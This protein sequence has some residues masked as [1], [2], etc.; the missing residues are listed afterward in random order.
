[1][2]PPMMPRPM[3][4]PC[5]ALLACTLSVARAES[6]PSPETSA[7]L[8]PPDRVLELFTSHGCSSCPSADRLLG[9]LLERDATL[10]GLEYHVDYWN[11]LVHGNAGNFVDPFSDPAWTRRQHDY[12]EQ[13]LLGRRD[14][15]T[16]QA[17]VDGRHVAVGSDAV[18]IE[19]ALGAA[20]DADGGAPGLRVERSGNTVMI[21]VSGL[22]RGGRGRGP[23]S[24]PVPA[25]GEVALVH[26][27][28]ETRTPITGGENQGL[29]LV[30]HRVVTL[31]ESLGT[32]DETGALSV[33]AKAPA[34]PSEGCA[35]LV[36]Y[37]DEVTRLA[38]RLCPDPV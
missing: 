12:A 28:R 6:A 10:I 15:Y 35:V 11:S 30:N 31:V 27:L 7:P 16:P 5:V 32:V 37:G 8:A 29:E 14:I 33:R 9:D 18:R 36:R 24:A 2:M 22:T 3:I 1:M 23:L 34:D 19:G 25:A 17:I 13:P 20:P 4:L 26:F 38:G 21:E